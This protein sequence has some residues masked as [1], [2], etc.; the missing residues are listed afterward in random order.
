[1]TRPQTSPFSIA[2]VVVT[3]FMFTIEHI[4]TGKLR[5]LST[6]R[7]QRRATVSHHFGRD[8][9]SSL[10]SIAITEMFQDSAFKCILAQKE[11]IYGGGESVKIVG[12]AVMF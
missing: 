2:V 3:I 7:W 1:M 6:A 5:F 4:N 9:F 11:S 10:N 8:P 12:L